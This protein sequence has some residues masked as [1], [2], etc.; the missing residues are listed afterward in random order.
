[1]GIVVL[2]GCQLASHLGRESLGGFLLD[3]VRVH[4]DGPALAAHWLSPTEMLHGV[5]ALV[6]VRWAG[7][8]VHLLSSCEGDWGQECEDLVLLLL[9]GRLQMAFSGVDGG[10]ICQIRPA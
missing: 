8:W 2:V 4:L 3:A 1:M 7:F 10:F 5:R 9:G 6:L